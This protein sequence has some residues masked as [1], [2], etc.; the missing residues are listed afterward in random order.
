M[1]VPSHVFDQTVAALFAPVGP[2]LEGDEVSEIMINGH[3]EI[4]V[5][6]SGRLYLTGSRFASEHA[7]MSAL[8]NLSQ[9]VGR[10]LNPRKPILEARLPDGSRVEAI[11]PP[12]ASSGPVVCIRRFRRKQLTLNRLVELGTITRDVGV[13]LRTIL[14][15]RDNVIVAG[16]SGSG[17]TSLL[18]VLASLAPDDERVVVIEDSQEL[19]LGLSHVVHLE[20]QPADVRGRGGVTIRELLRATLRMRPDRIVIGEIRGGEALDLIQAMTSGHRGCLS[21]VHATLPFDTLSRLETMALMSDVDVPLNVLRPQIASAVDTIVQ[22]SRCSDGSRYVTHVT[23]V[24]GYDPENG[25]RISH[26][27]ERPTES[28]R[29]E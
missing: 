18:N 11:I 5:E 19:Q 16:G 23:E 6:R 8:R 20:A 10:E 9:F 28:G 7:L 22:V 24:L 17:K 13:L 12:A 14:T 4:Y 26:L 21:T 1:S 29:R 25:Y 15:R 2:F 3:K 27:F